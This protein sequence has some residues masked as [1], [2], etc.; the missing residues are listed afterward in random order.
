MIVLTNFNVGVLSDKTLIRDL[1]HVILAHEY[2]ARDAGGRL[3]HYSGGVYVDNGDL[4]VKRQV[5]QLTVKFGNA[6][7]W[8]RTLAHE[9]IEY[10]TLDA[11]ELV[12]RP[13]PDNINLVNG[14]L[15]IWTGELSAHSPSILSSIRIPLTYDP[16]A[17]CPKIAEFVDEVFPKDSAELA[18]EILGDLIAAD[19]SIQKAICVVGEGGNGKSVFCQLCANFVGEQNVVHLSLQK[20]DNDRFAPARLYGKLANI[21]TDLPGSRVEESSAFKAITGCDRITAELKYRDAFEFRPFA[22]LIFS[23]NHYPAARSGSQSYFDRWLLIPFDR[24]FR[25]SQGDVPRT[26]LDN[27]LSAAREMSGALN[28][29]LPA[30]RRLRNNNRFSETRSVRRTCRDFEVTSD[31]FRIWLEAETECTPSS[32]ISQ[33]ALHAAHAQACLQTNRPPFT[34]QMFG[35]ML[36]KHRP[37]IREFQRTVGGT[38]QWMYG[39]IDL[40]HS[41]HSMGEE[42]PNR[43]EDGI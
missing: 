22:R 29:A 37:D 1:A 34:K 12:A 8:N 19:R 36:R 23:A 14:V 15:N 18:W 42:I 30:L 7:R 5:K 10:I 25:G 16:A 17:E 33:S 35:R 2:F 11:P 20:L 13:D 21:C 26:A 41:N 6:G 38:K 32:L 43:L 40:R 31:P 28:R 39:G 3:F 24:R 4:Y 9:V 27:Q